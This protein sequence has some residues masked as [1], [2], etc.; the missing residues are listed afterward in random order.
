GNPG[1]EATRLTPRRTRRY[2]AG[3]SRVKPGALRCLN[4]CPTKCAD[5]AS[6][7]CRRPHLRFDSGASPPSSLRV[8]EQLLS[9]EASSAGH[10]CSQCASDLSVNTSCGEASYEIKQYS[11][12]RPRAAASRSSGI[13]VPAVA[14][15]ARRGGEPA[16]VGAHTGLLG[17]PVQRCA[18]AQ[19]RGLSGSG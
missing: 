18:A 17:N 15:V 8:L 2:H 16:D 9:L 14:V 1:S 12:R 10:A 11:G 19:Y 4:L 3:R 5:K 7:A 13:A 6:G